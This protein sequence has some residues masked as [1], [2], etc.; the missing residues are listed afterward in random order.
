MGMAFY[1]ISTI[2]LIVEIGIF[3][4]VL[5][6]V[7]YAKQLDIEMHHMFVYPAVFLQAIITFFWMFPNAAFY[8]SDPE[9][10]VKDIGLFI[11]AIHRISGLIALLLALYL[12]VFFLFKRWEN[13]NL[14]LNR[15]LMLAT[16]YSW[17]TAFISGFLF[18]FSI[19]FEI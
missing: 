14:K 5:L 2:V 18:Y 8:V 6:G 11:L 17:M 4:A 13:S 3:A 19:L 7:K 10:P 1:P 15:K 9:S 16:Y 12:V